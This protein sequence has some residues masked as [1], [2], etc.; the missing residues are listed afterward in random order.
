MAGE[1]ATVP[2]IAFDGSGNPSAFSRGA[3]RGTKRTD[4]A[5]QVRRPDAAKREGE[6]QAGRDLSRDHNTSSDTAKAKTSTWPSEAAASKRHH[7]APYVQVTSLC[8]DRPKAE[9]HPPSLPSCYPRQPSGHN[10]PLRPLA[11]PQ[12]LSLAL[13]QDH[14][15]PHQQELSAARQSAGVTAAWTAWVSRDS[16]SRRFGRTHN[17]LVTE[18]SLSAEC[19]LVYFI[20]NALFPLSLSKFTISVSGALPL[21]RAVLLN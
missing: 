19:S 1:G 3:D 21:N 7:P 10:Q 12:K 11:L 6:T 4:P 14:G 2:R 20:H 15:L 5:A 9:I 18:S 8:R 13:E 16:T 17:A